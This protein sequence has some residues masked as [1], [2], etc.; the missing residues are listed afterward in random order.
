MRHTPLENAREDGNRDGGAA[1]P[2]DAR[3]WVAVERRPVRQRALALLAVALVIPILP[4]CDRDAGR[5]ERPAAVRAY[6]A[7]SAAR[8]LLPPELASLL[9][10]EP[11]LAAMGDTGRATGRRCRVDTLPQL[12][13]LR[14]R[15]DMR[16]GDTTVTLFA[17]RTPAGELRRTEVVRRHPDGTA[18][19]ATWD[20]ADQ[21][22]T[23]TQFGGGR[24]TQT[25]NRDMEA[26]LARALAYVGRR[27]MGTEC[28]GGNREPGTGDR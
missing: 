21:K 25:T 5:A 14:L 16:R 12:R 15:F 27:A 8:G 20:A 3:P 24:A 2:D 9:A 6:D 4:G 13:H 11:M 18:L 26:P 22:T 7:D 1:T 17:R 10:V 28:G 23:V 19:G